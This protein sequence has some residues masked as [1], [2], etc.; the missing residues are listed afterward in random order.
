MKR[1]RALLQDEWERAEASARPL[2]AE[3]EVDA[4]AGR[5]WRLGEE[6]AQADP[7]RRRGVFR[8]LVDGI[9]LRFDQIQKGKRTECPLNSGEIHLKTGEGSIFG[10]V[11]RGE[12]NFTEQ[13]L[14]ITLADWR[15][16]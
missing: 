14:P 11:S 15:A 13:K 3:A 7:A 4:I 9:E 8:L 2:D 5:L 16:A 10:S 6:M 12:R 1:Q